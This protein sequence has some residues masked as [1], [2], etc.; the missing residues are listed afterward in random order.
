MAQERSGFDESPIATI[1]VPIFAIIFFGYLGQ[2][3]AWD[4]RRNGAGI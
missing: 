1:T 3:D 2:H 4:Y